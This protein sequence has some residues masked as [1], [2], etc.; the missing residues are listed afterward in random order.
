MK[1]GKLLLTSGGIT[2][3][4]IQKALVD[5]LG[6]PLRES[7]ALFVPTAIYAFPHSANWAWDWIKRLGEL[8]WKEFGVLE[9]TALSSLP[10][11]FWLPQLEET[12]ALIMGGGNEFYLSYWMEISG[13]FDVLPHLMEQGQVYVGVSAG[14]MVVTPALNFNLDRFKATGVYH[15]D[16]FDEGMPSSAG[17]TKTLPLVDFVVRPHFMS[18]YFPQTTPENLEK[19]AAKVAFPLYALDDESAVKVVDGQVEVVSNGT[20]RLFAKP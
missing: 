6:K 1:K 5:L 11:E 3:E 12:D 13:L 14:T 19:W 18:D 15:D 7:S 9:L 2:N 8:E 4:S 20:W 16:E 17:S 10:R